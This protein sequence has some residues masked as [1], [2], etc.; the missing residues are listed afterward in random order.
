M[1]KIGYRTLKTAIGVAL[2]IAIAQW[3]GLNFYASAGIITILCIQKTRRSSLRISWQRFLA[4]SVGILFGAAFFEI[5]G[6]HPLALASMLVIFIPIVVLLKAQEG[7]ATSTVIILHLYTLQEV[8]LAIVLNEFGIIIIGIGIALL[9]NTYMPSVEGELKSIQK[10]IEVNYKKI[11][12]QFAIYLKEGDNN[13]DGI[14]ITETVDLLKKG[15]NIA[16]QN[17]EN[18]LLRYDDQYYH[19]F[20][21]RE[22]QFYIIERMMPIISSL[23]HTVLQGLKIAN[24]LEELSE[25]VEPGK[26]PID[27]LERLY[28]LQDE[29]K[30]MDLPKD[31]EEFEIRSALFSFVKEVEQYLI[32]K[33]LFRTET[34]KQ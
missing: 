24:Y 20:K 2:A 23:D 21:M 25:G 5:I 15:K 31:R 10:S 26:G 16:L 12:L 4:C 33:R 6:Y 7:I 19:Y 9:M 28:E 14:E 27:F 34:S 13:W 32:I 18:H 3:F 8:S 1:F 29:F 11:F 30:Q 22:K 17:I